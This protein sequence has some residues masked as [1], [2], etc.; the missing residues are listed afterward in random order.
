V[1]NIFGFRIPPVVG[2]V[3]GIAPDGARDDVKPFV[4][5]TAGAPIV[6][7]ATVRFAI[8]R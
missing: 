2:A 7:A 3:L 4:S 5:L 1:L 8:W 6:N